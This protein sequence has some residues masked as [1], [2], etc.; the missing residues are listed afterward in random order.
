[1][2]VFRMQGRPVFGS[3]AEKVCVP[4][5][6]VSHFLSQVENILR[7]NVRCGFFDEHSELV[8]QHDLVLTH[9]RFPD[10]ATR[11]ELIQLKGYVVQFVLGDVYG[12]LHLRDSGNLIPI[13]SAWMSWRS[14]SVGSLL[15]VP[16]RFSKAHRV[17]PDLLERLGNGNA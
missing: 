7:I 11:N 15:D 4:M 12:D 10:E 1:M 9:V 5:V 14:R 13:A 16:C 2:I 6:W 8:G 17:P 3:P